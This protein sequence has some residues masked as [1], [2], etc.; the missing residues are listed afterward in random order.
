M[1]KVATFQIGKNGISTTVLQTLTRMLETHKFIRIAALQASGRTRDSIKTMADSL[2]NQL[3]VSC[4]YTIIGF[5]I[6]LRKRTEPTKHR[7]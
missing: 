7:R 3:P 6:I 2:V 5:T 1:N 4:T